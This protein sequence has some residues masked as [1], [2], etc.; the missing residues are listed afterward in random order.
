MEAKQRNNELSTMDKVG[1]G[2]Q[3]GLVIY[4]IANAFLKEA[5]GKD[6]KSKKKAKKKMKEM[7][8]ELKQAKKMGYCK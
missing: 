2:V 7:K 6:K 4:V 3:L 8:K 1:A 5:K